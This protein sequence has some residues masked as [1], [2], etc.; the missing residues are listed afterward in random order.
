MGRQAASTLR[1]GDHRATCGLKSGTNRGSPARDHR[2][3]GARPPT[4]R[5]CVIPKLA[6]GS[7]PRTRSA[8]KTLVRTDVGAS[9][10]ACWA[11]RVGLRVINGPLILAQAAVGTLRPW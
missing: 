6:R 11:T 8:I 9:V 5:S 3:P 4:D 1:G 2:Y 7:I 10:L